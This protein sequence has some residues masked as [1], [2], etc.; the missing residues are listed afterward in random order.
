MPQKREAVKNGETKNQ[1]FKTRYWNYKQK[2]QV[3]IVVCFFFFQCKQNG[4]AMAS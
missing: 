4:S 1:K 3:F 2:N